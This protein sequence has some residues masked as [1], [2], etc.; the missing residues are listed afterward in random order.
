MLHEN[1]V[2]NSNST[3]SFKQALNNI[4]CTGGIPFDGCVEADGEIHRFDVQKKGDKAGW[5]KYFHDTPQGGPFGNWATGA[6][7]QWFVK[8]ETEMSTEE[9]EIYT[10]RIAADRQ[11]RKKEGQ[12]RRAAA[13]REAIAVWGSLTPAGADHPYLVKKAVGAY[14]IRLDGNSLVIP[15]RDTAGQIHS[16]QHIKPDGW[17]QFFTAGA[18]TGHFHTISRTEGGPTVVYIGEGYATGA[19]IHEAT[20]AMVIIAF[21]A[22][23][24]LS[25]VQAVRAKY[26]DKQIVVCADDDRWT[27]GNP[28]MTKGKEAAEAISASLVSPKFKTLD[29]KKTTDFNDLHAMEGLDTV[30]GQLI[31]VTPLPIIRG[32]P[33]IRAMRGHL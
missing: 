7:G 11:A 26:P 31:S 10:A 16:L 14:N 2:Q 18:V 28:G 27:D 5:Y 29:G 23:N 8:G 24:L 1:Q 17:K 21:N 3:E 15:C 32:N 6:K 22:G 9:H 30:R 33:N 20:G 19:S 25:V 13:Q 4:V 12:R